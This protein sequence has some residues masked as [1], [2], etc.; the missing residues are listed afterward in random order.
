M[1]TFIARAV[2][3]LGMEVRIESG[4]NGIVPYHSCGQGPQTFDVLNR[5]LIKGSIP[6]TIYV[7]V[8]QA[9]S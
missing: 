7:R 3:E 4:L 1:K 9:S 5:I 6:T 8:F 2:L